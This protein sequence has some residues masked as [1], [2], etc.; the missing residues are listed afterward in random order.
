MNSVLW[1]ISVYFIP[2][3]CLTG[4]LYH[5]TKEGSEGPSLSSIVTDHIQT[6]KKLLSENVTTVILLDVESGDKDKFG[7]VYQEFLTTVQQLEMY[8]CAYIQAIFLRK[9][10]TNEALN[11]LTR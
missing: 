10:K 4:K 7:F 11:A 5:D 3:F 6:I 2:L 9:M 8:L 1:Y